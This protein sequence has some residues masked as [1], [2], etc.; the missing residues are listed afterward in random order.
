MAKNDSMAKP[1]K[2]IFFLLNLSETNPVIITSKICRII[3]LLKIS[4]KMTSANSQYCKFLGFFM[5]KYSFF[6]LINNTV[7]LTFGTGKK[8]P[9]E[10]STTFSIFNFN[11]SA[12]N[13]NNF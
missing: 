2:V 5:L 11:P 12:W 4:T 7:L 6:G 13:F 10:T 1:M 9:G 3:I 8:D